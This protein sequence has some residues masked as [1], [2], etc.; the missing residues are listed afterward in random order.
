[1]LLFHNVNIKSFLDDSN[2][3]YDE[4]IIKEGKV[5]F[6][7]YY[8]SMKSITMLKILFNDMANK[9]MVINQKNIIMDKLSKY[10]NYVLNKDNNMV[11]ELIK[12]GDKYNFKSSSSDELIYK[13]STVLNYIV[14]KPNKFTF[15]HD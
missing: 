9:K 8:A 1:M 10:S 11:Y 15:S 4:N 7:D 2:I 12:N 13:I 5:Y 6:Q 14:D 3:K